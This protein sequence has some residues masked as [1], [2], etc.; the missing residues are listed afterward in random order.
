[1]NAN[2]KRGGR[3]IAIQLSRA[4]PSARVQLTKRTTEIDQWLRSMPNPP[5]CVLA[6]GGDGTA[7]ALV[8][9]SHLRAWF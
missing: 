2:A 1:M 3:R 7:I 6:A 9:W 5:E 4:L 8:Y